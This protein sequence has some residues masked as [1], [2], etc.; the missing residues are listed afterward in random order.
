MPLLTTMR[1]TPKL[2]DEQRALREAWEALTEKVSLLTPLVPSKPSTT[3]KVGTAYKGAVHPKTKILIL[4][5]TCSSIY[6]AR[7]FLY[8]KSDLSD[9][10]GLFP[11]YQTALY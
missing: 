2:S 10:L 8:D 3:G 9:V 1:R 4:T 6:P 7:L 11:F 5:F